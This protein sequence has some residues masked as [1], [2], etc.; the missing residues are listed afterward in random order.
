M[1]LGQLASHS[2]RSTASPDSQYPQLFRRYAHTGYDRFDNSLSGHASI[3]AAEI[4]KVKIDCKFLFEKSHWGV[5]SQAKNPAGIIYLDLNFRQPPSHRLKSAIIT[6]RLDEDYADTIIKGGFRRSDYYDFRE[7]VPVQIGTYGPIQINGEARRALKTSRLSIKPELDVG[8]LAGL[9]GVGSESETQYE[10]EY[11]WSFSSQAHPDPKSKRCPSAYRI[12]EWELSENELETQSSHSNTI[13]TAFSFQ[14]DG[15]PFLIHV[16]VK[17]KLQSRFRN[18]EHGVKSVVRRARKY[19]FGNDSPDTPY[20]TTLI[21]FG[22]R[23]KFL[24]PLD[25][26]AKGLPFAMEQENMRSIPV[27][28]PSS[29][30]ATFKEV[31]RD[32]QTRP[33]TV[34]EPLEEDAP[35]QYQAGSVDQHNLLDSM[36]LGQLATGEEILPSAWVT[37]DEGAVQ[38]NPCVPTTRNLAK[39]LFSLTDPHIEQTLNFASAPTSI[40]EDVRRTRKGRYIGVRSQAQATQEGSLSEASSTTFAVDESTTPDGISTSRTSIH[41]ARPYPTI[42]SLLRL[43]GL[44]K[45]MQFCMIFMSSL[46]VDISPPEPKVDRLDEQKAKDSTARNR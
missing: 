44:I 8:G 37:G 19:K 35:N 31:P 25:E 26:L 29:H 2:S 17:G 28:I 42:V 21:N 11:R 13:H 30:R 16:S 43:A 14:H 34:T 3:G 39:A 20:A 22:G 41:E 18:M 33:Y 46:G 23:H 10:Q 7:D 9:G 40:D 36:Q 38:D 4:G 6:V 1:E 32:E 15:H 45:V 24:K 27:E 5:L 12:L